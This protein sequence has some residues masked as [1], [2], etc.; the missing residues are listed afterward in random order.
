[1]ANKHLFALAAVTVYLGI[2][3][4]FGYALMVSMPATNLLAGTYVTLT[5]PLWLKASPV[6]PPVFP[7]LF[8]FKDQGR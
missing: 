6:R 3:A 7:W 5:W 1:M 4:R 8:T 2:G